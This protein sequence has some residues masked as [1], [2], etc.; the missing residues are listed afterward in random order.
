MPGSGRSRRRSGAL[1]L[2]FDELHWFP[3]EPRRRGGPPALARDASLAVSL[4]APA[5]AGSSA[6]AL[7][8]RPGRAVAPARRTGWSR[9]RKRRFAT[10]F[11]PATLAVVAAGAAPWAMHGL[12]GGGAAAGTGAAQPAA[13][14]ALQ[15]RTATLDRPVAQALPVAPAAAA[16]VAG[17][18][19]TP[20]PGIHWHRSRA[21]G[22]PQAGRLVG[23]VQLPVEGPGWVTWDPVRD[24][25][26]NRAARLYGTAGLVR[27][28][29][30]VMDDYRA[31]HPDA[32]PVVVGDISRKGGGPIDEHVSHENGLD[33]DV[34]YPRRDGRPVPPTRVSQIDHRLAQDLVRRFVAAGA[35]MVFVGPHT[36]LR[37]PDGVV[38]TWPNHDNHLHVRLP[39][40]FQR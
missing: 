29:L 7:P 21:V 40:S 16:T 17:A 34:Y 35:Q 5:F 13:R 20:Q 31:A 3:P 9:T 25:S 11:V 36:R 32:P 23:G 1:W 28:L 15:V 30:A 22:L 2:D 38:A 4:P 39:R 33:V 18:V 14:P 8:V 19:A 26:P 6:P 24:R 27:T 12:A 37:G 10:R